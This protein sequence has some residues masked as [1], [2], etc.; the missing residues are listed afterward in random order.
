MTSFGCKRLYVY[1]CVETAPVP[2]FGRDGW[3]RGLQA[4]FR[5]KRTFGLAD[6]ADSVE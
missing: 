6:V 1:K 2:S 5:D 3:E 4:S